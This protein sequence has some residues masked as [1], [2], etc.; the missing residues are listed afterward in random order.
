MASFLTD[1]WVSRLQEMWAAHQD[2][3]NP[4]GGGVV[5]DFPPTPQEPDDYVVKTPAA[6]IP[7]R[8]GDR[9]SSAMCKVYKLIPV[10]GDTTKFDLS[11]IMNGASQWELRCLHISKNED[12]AGDT[13]CVTGRLKGGLRYVQWEDCV[14]D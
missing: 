10:S 13:I 1:E 2:S 9:I 14:A 4:A 6:G 12:A 7:K 8:V 5:H 3:A 11:P